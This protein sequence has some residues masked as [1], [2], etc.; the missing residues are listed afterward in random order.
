M[1]PSGTFDINPPP[2][3]WQELFW[4]C[5]VDPDS[6]QSH[7]SF[8]VRRVLTD[9]RWEH[10]AWLRN[11][12]GDQAIR[13]WILEHR[14]SSLSAQQLRFWELILDLPGEIVDAWLSDP[15]RRLWWDRSKP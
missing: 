10:V 2:L 4:D 8:V 7:R 3:N 13:D 14:G 1:A 15:M 12:V 6:W 5:H 9:G 11:A